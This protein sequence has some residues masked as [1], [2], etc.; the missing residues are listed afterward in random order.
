MVRLFPRRVRVLNSTQ[1]YQRRERENGNTIGQK[2][3][4]APQELAVLKAN[5]AAAGVTVNENDSFHDC[6]CREGMPLDPQAI[7]PHDDPLGYV[8]KVARKR[9]IPVDGMV[10]VKGREQQP[11]APPKT[12]LAPDII[13]NLMR[14]RADKDPSL[15]ATE[16][17]RKRLREDVINKHAPPPSL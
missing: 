6:L 12:G 10:T 17:K 11:V 14:Q 1:V 8:E 7:V 4:N 2:F 5:A 3:R 9:G 15:V 13:D 16:A